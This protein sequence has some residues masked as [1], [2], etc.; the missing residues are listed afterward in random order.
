[1]HQ[2]SKAVIKVMRYGLNLVCFPDAHAVDL[3]GKQIAGQ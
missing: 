1:M 3:V 2:D